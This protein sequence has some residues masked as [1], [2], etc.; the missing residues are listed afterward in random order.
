[1]SFPLNIFLLFN[2]F[3]YNDSKTVI[4]GHHGVRSECLNSVC[5]GLAFNAKL[6]IYL[7]YDRNV[8]NQLKENEEYCLQIVYIIILY[9]PFISFMNPQFD[10][11]KK[12]D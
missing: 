8:G 9:Y 3:Y 12:Y 4:R 10:I 5:E 6:F 1:M 11:L 7:I 2:F